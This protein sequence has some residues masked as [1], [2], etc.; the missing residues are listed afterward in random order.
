MGRVS[1]SRDNGVKEI[2][3]RKEI[4]GREGEREMR[5]AQGRRGG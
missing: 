1:E 2:L 4:R 5:E 3:G